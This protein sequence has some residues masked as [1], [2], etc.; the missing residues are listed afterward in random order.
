MATQPQRLNERDAAQYLGAC[1][2]RTLQD[3]RL[4][5]KWPAYI[6]LGKRVVYEVADLD[7][8]LAAGR[9][10]HVLSGSN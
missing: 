10:E 5:K 6:K 2:M 9:V 3:W 4:R 8:F 7:A 1:T